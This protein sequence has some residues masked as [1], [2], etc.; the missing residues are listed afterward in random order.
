[1]EQRTG[2]DRSFEGL[3]VEQCAPTLAGLKPANLFCFC[4]TDFDTARAQV[5]SWDKKLRPFGVRL[6]VWKE[7]SGRSAGV[8]YAYRPT[9]LRHVLEC[10]ENRAFLARE[11]YTGET[12]EELLAQLADRFA[13]N[14]EFPHEIGVFL[15]YPLEDVVGFIE[16]RGHNF[17][18]CGYW[19]SYGDPVAAR[20]RFARYRACT[21]AYK[22]L[23]GRGISIIQLVAA[24]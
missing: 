7:R 2:T 3:L 17:T 15:G 22:E 1:M 23:F 10:G 12:V 13:A 5:E 21:S 18:C 24:A 20:M 19:K 8:V 9:Y 16:N 6:L 11:G 4:G 14:E